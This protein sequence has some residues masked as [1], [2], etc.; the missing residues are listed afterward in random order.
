GGAVAVWASSGLTAP[1][2]QSAMNRAFFQLMFDAR[3]PTLGEV[4]VAAKG[5]IADV[6]VRR[7]WIFFGDPAMQLKGMS[8]LVRTVPAA[9]GPAVTGALPV[10]PPIAGS[11]SPAGNAPATPSRD[12]TS[13]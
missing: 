9:P 13:T 7:T 6:D 5:L 10:A 12:S 2:D 8:D 1:A 4:I 11:S 3:Y